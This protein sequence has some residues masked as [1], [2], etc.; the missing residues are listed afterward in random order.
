MRKPE[1]MSPGKGILL[2]KTWEDIHPHD[3]VIA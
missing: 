1:C 3:H 2:T